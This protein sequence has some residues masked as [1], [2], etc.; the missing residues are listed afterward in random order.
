MVTVLVIDT[1]TSIDTRLVTIILLTIQ[2]IHIFFGVLRCFVIRVLGGIVPIFSRKNTYHITIMIGMS[3][4]RKG[5]ENVNIIY[6]WI[7]FVSS[8]FI[9]LSSV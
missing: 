3:K 1:H 7:F 8:M 5:R 2:S 4:K 9:L 6:V